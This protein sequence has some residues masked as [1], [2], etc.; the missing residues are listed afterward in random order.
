MCAHACVC[1]CI[2]YELGENV[3]GEILSCYHGL[4]GR[5]I[6]AGEEGKQG[7][8]GSHVEWKKKKNRR[9]KNSNV[10]IPV[11]AWWLTNLTSIHEDAGS[12]PDLAQWIKDPAFP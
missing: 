11:M 9:T 10:G 3:Y 7:G 4:F 6:H 1:V 12:I 2:R 5:K 8:K